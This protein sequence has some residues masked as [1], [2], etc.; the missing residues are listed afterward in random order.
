M[1]ITSILKNLNII[2]T[3]T[4]VIVCFHG[5]SLFVKGEISANII[6]PSGDWWIARAIIKPE[7]LR[8]QGLGSEMLKKLKEA[9]VRQGCKR[10]IVCPEGYEGKTRRQFNFYKKNGF[11]KIKKE[12]MLEWIPKL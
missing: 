2:E 1:N 4:D 7:S 6:N 11:V 8:D 5:T 12:N 10:L 9:A 3:D